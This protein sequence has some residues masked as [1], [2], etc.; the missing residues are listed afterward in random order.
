[1]KNNI[2]KK[3]VSGLMVLVM[4]IG[5]MWT[6]EPAHAATS[7][8]L[9]FVSGTYDDTNKC[10]VV[11][12]SGV[13]LTSLE[14]IGTVSG[15]VKIDGVSKTASWKDAADGS[16]YQLLI[17]YTNVQASVTS[18]AGVNRAVYVTVPSGTTIGSITTSQDFHVRI[19]GDTLT[20][21]MCLI[22]PVDSLPTEYHF[23][24]WVHDGSRKAALLYLHKINGPSSSTWESKDGVK[25]YIDGQE[26]TVKLEGNQ[27]YYFIPITYANLGEASA[28]SYANLTNTHIVKVP[29]GTS[30]GT[31]TLSQDTYYKV[32]KNG[33][34]EM[35]PATASCY[36]N[37]WDAGGGKYYVWL[38]PASGRT[39]MPIIDTEYSRKLLYDDAEKSGGIFKWHSSSD[40]YFAWLLYAELESGASAASDVKEHI[41]ALPE[42]TYVGNM[43]L[44]EDIQLYVNGSTI[45]LASDATPYTGASDWYQSG[46]YYAALISRK[47]PSETNSYPNTYFDVYIDGQ[48]VSGVAMCAQTKPDFDLVRFYTNSGK[49]SAGDHI[50]RIPKGTMIGKSRITSDLYY[51]TTASAIYRLVFKNETTVTFSNDVVNAGENVYGLFL[52]ATSSPIPND[53]YWPSNF[54]FAWD[55]QSEVARHGG[56]YLNDEW[57]TNTDVD[58]RKLD[59]GYWYV[60]LN[61][62]VRSRIKKGDI[63]K[64]SGSM[65]V[66]EEIVTFN[67]IS[68]IRNANGSFSQYDSTIADVA[69]EEVI[70][71][72]LYVNVDEYPSYTIPSTPLIE[73]AG[74]SVKVNGNETTDY[75]LSQVGSYAVER[76]M[77]NVSLIEVVGNNQGNTIYKQN[78]YLYK[79][80]DANRD[81]Q[82]S[83]KDL[84]RAKMDAKDAKEVLGSINDL[85]YD[86]VVDAKDAT[87][88]A[89]LLVGKI[90]AAE[91][92]ENNDSIVYGAI[93]DC[94]YLGSH[95]S[96]YGLNS[97][98]GR[99]EKERVNLRKA[100]NY[101]KSQNVQVII[102][103]SDISDKGESTSY[104]SLVKDIKSVYPDEATRPKFIFT[105]DNHEW[106]DAW[107]G[108][109]GHTKVCEFEDTQKRFCDKLA[110]LRDNSQS[111]H[112]HYEVN[113]Y[114]FIGVSSDGMNG[115]WATYKDTTIEW[116]RTTLAAAAADDA[117]GKKPIFFA[118]HQAP[119]NTVAGSN[120]ADHFD[121]EAMEKLLKEYPQL[122]V[123]TSHTHVALQ[124]ERSI[125]QRDYTTLNTA[126]TSYAGGMSS[127]ANIASNLMSE[128]YQFN[129]GLLI[130]A[131]KNTVDVERCDFW[132]DEKIKDNWVFET[133]NNAS[134]Y[135]KYT[136][137][138]ANNRKAPEFSE[139]A[140]VKTTWNDDGTVTLTFD[141]ATHEDFVKY[142]IVKAYKDGSTTPTE[143]KY[144]DFY[145]DGLDA[146]GDT[147]E[148]TLTG[149]DATAEYKFEVYAV[150]SWGKTGKL[151][152]PLVTT[153]NSSGWIGNSV[154]LDFGSAYANKTVMATMEICGDAQESYDPGL[155]FS[156]AK[157]AAQ[158]QNQKYV[159]VDKAKLVSG[160]WTEIAVPLELNENGQIYLAASRTS[161]N[162]TSGV[163]TVKIRNAKVV[164]EIESYYTYDAAAVGGAWWASQKAIDFGSEYANK[165]VYVT[166]TV[167]GNADP[168]K[169][170]SMGLWGYKTA[171]DIGSLNA[172]SRE[173]LST[174]QNWSKVTFKCQLDANGKWLISPGIKESKYENFTIF[175]KDVEVYEY[176]SKS[177]G[178]QSSDQFFTLDF[179]EDETVATYDTVEVQMELRGVISQAGTSQLGFYCDKTVST[180]SN[181]SAWILGGDELNTAIRS[182]EWTTVTVSLK[183]DGSKKVKLAASRTQN[184]PL[185]ASTFEL[186]IR[187]VKKVIQ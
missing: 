156:S 118:I 15:S 159:S 56:I 99:G 136:D 141:A 27:S 145:F 32:S 75:T 3:I 135:T 127:V 96:L 40:G 64:V 9:E 131:D 92:V 117:T 163:F 121:S 177:T 21:G 71:D 158:S 66:G 65:C 2:V 39:V 51:K 53:T 49:L 182:G 146:V 170:A 4:V 108:I 59:S 151:E 128:K 68:F 79:T 84:V 161:N 19:Y 11:N 16:G 101:Y 139:D 72:D 129:Q 155:G 12:V 173:Q 152:K 132:N 41:I 178:W 105:G 38:K 134:D 24:H 116:V 119:M 94:H 36:S 166:L 69:D 88:V 97:P 22:E 37:A 47:N 165:E 106:Y 167:C 44:T 187:N 62:G 181:Y 171:S 91:V 81:N 29:A 93:S 67:E 125:H 87:I 46:Q 144:V 120:G 20:S 140:S 112:T 45:A 183:L 111:T 86:D 162:G 124:D 80:G 185:T 149:L 103:N 164:E 175:V 89:Q 95:V 154:L 176:Y 110:E 74:V 61:M 104:E 160:E 83:V 33:V 142:Y 35:I 55:S 52:N 98:N 8:A 138:R 148:F 6:G 78:V 77:E 113:G 102:F 123:I 18:H 114:H 70:L 122:V 82:V 48:L 34:E 50:I 63:I 60:D 85:N 17:P 31:M 126:S 7:T 115:G 186:Y 26:K 76:T 107:D 1:M 14:A 133:S 30:I 57:L 147:V 10:Y 90:T 169:T 73:G 42:G 168:N 5:L 174:Y 54:E 13:G 58:L 143:Y 150:E 43:I 100:L 184:D 153:T 137:A 130:R 180:D 172:I 109:N 28:A 25:I 23:Y 179:S 157:D